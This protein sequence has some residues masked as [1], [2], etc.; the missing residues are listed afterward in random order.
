MEVLKLDLPGREDIAW[1]KNTTTWKYEQKLRLWL[2]F[3]K[4]MSL[5]IQV[6]TCSG[7]IKGKFF[8][9]VIMLTLQKINVSLKKYASKNLDSICLTVRMKLKFST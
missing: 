4:E 2:V 8:L 5:V 9:N 3:S 7:E 1:H 6:A